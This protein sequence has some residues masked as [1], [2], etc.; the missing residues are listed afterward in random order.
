M[1]SN[2]LVNSRLQTYLK[3]SF[4]SISSLFLIL[5]LFLALKHRSISK[6]QSKEIYSLHGSHLK[7]KLQKLN[8]CH[9]TSPHHPTSS[10]PRIPG[11][12]FPSI[13]PLKHHSLP[14]PRS[15]SVILHQRLISPDTQNTTNKHT[16]KESTQNLNCRY[17]I[18]IDRNKLQQQ[19]ND[20]TRNNFY[21]YV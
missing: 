12:N 9:A 10:P 21:S 3:T 11:I 6:P 5:Y 16:R 17:S 14:Y 2:V 1:R 20:L 19:Q 7:L 15:T 8:L 4:Y 18:I 13:P